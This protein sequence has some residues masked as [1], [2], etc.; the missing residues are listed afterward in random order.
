MNRSHKISVLFFFFFFYENY[1]L[2]Q[3]QEQMHSHTST[4]SPSSYTGAEQLHMGDGTGLNIFIFSIGDSQVYST[5][6]PSISLN[7]S[8]LLHVPDISKNLISVS[9]FARDDNVY[10]QFH[11]NCC[12]VKS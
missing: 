6:I 9:K 4:S 2:T 12:F 7:L 8:N 5:T 1:F 10:F 3:H 11:S